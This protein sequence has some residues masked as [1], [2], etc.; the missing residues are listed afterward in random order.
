[1]VVLRFAW[2]KGA[3]EPSGKLEMLDGVDGLEQKIGVVISRVVA[4]VKAG[5]WWRMA[6]RLIY[7]RIDDDDNGGGG[8]DNKLL[9][10]MG[11]G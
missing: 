2:Q 1:M 4:R 5:R 7:K 6:R 11:R 3:G 10:L 8:V 9:S